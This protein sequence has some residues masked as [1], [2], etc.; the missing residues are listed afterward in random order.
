MIYKNEDGSIYKIERE[1]ADFYVGDDSENI[2]N[3]RRIIENE[4]SIDEINE[5]L[6]YLLKKV[7]I[8]RHKK[9]HIELPKLNDTEDI[10][11]T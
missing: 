7:K 6:N 11:I 4:N 5:V 2:N 9:E 10:K 8:I 3:Y 1:E